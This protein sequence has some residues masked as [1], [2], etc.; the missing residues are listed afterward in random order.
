MF[1]ELVDII[2]GVEVWLCFIINQSE[3][4]EVCLFIVEVLELFSLFLQGMVGSCLL[5]V[6]VYG[7]GFVNFKYCGN[8]V[9]VIVVMCFVDNYGVV[10][11]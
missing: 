2:L 10:I 7:E 6:V 3:C 11:E 9:Q 5:I 1:V 8:L 4:F